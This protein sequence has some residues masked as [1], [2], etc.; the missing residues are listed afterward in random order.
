MKLT[1]WP[2]HGPKRSVVHSGAAR[3]GA[4]DARCSQVSSSVSYILSS[5]RV[6][7]PCVIHIGVDAQVRPE[8]VILI[9][10]SITA[11]SDVSGMLLHATAG[12]RPCNVEDQS[13]LDDSL[14]IVHVWVDGG[15]V[16]PEL[17]TLIE[18]IRDLDW[19]ALV[20]CS[21]SSS[22]GSSSSSSTPVLIYDVKAATTLACQTQT[23]SNQCR[24][25]TA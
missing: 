24:A 9:S 20:V 1:P 19:V 10:P 16:R 18:P 2:V 12:T 21:S 17:V 14:G 13:V 15:Q 8:L 6:H 22:S 23:L 7:S 25:L 11:T 5:F 4:K 3:E